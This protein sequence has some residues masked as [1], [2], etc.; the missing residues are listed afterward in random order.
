MSNANTFC[1]C[2]CVQ[3]NKNQQRAKFKSI[4][5]HVYARAL[6]MRTTQSGEKIQFIYRALTGLNKAKIN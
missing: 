4:D 2:E 5:S 6:N 3:Q 1:M